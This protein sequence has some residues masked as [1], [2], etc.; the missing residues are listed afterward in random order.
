MRIVV[1]TSVVFAGLHSR[2]GAAHAVLRGCLTGRWTP[3]VTVPLATEYE[4]VMLRPELRRGSGLTRVDLDEFLDGFLASA[5]LV[6]VFF[7]WR[8][9]LRDEGDNFVLEAAVAGS[10]SAIVT[11]NVKDFLGGGLKF[12]SIHII[13]PARLLLAGEGEFR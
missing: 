11:Y 13:T 7:L 6:E 2:R 4:D 1:D 3:V 9:N 12:D 5:D 8:P 10:A